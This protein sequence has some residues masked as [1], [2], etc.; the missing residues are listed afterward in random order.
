MRAFKIQLN[1]ERLCIAGVG[2]DGVL[3]AI[4]DCVT[5]P[6]GTDSSLFVGGLHSP[7]AEHVRWVQHKRLR[8]GDEIRIKVVDVASVDAPKKKYRTHPAETLSAK[9]RYVRKMAKDLGWTIQTAT[10]RSS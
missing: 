6:K 10:A 4:V 8:A 2:D 3:S 9:K 1:G 7:T 5:R